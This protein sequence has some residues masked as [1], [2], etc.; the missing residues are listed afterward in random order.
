M[1]KN[2]TS[3]I[4][5]LS[6][7]STIPSAALNVESKTSPTKAKKSS[8]RVG[9]EC[10]HTGVRRPGSCHEGSQSRLYQFYTNPR[11][12]ASLRGDAVSRCRRTNGTAA[13]LR[14]IGEDDVT[15]RS[16]IRSYITRV[17]REMNI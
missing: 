12:K 9:L 3:L 5:D 15:T 4:K 14:S 7:K 10:F 2:K 1:S 11:V 13:R 8:Y 6:P 17:S 16:H